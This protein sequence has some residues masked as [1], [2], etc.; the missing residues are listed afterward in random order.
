MATKDKKSQPINDAGEAKS[1][2]DQTADAYAIVAIV[3]IAVIAMSV[4]VAGL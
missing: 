3:L 1:S 2:A 4:W